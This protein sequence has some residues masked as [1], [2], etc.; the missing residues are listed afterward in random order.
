[1]SQALEEAKRLA[2]NDFETEKA[3]AWAIIAVAE[4]ID[5]TNTILDGILN[6]VYNGIHVRKID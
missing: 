4:K 6:Q 2:S 3:I 1:M 5:E